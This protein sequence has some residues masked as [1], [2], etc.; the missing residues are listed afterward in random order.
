MSKETEIGT[1]THNSSPETIEL[2][3]RQEPEMDTSVTETSAGELTLKSVDEPIKQATDP[4]LRRVVEL[5]A[6]LAG[7]TEM[8][9]AENSEASGWRRNHD[10]ISPSGNRYDRL[11]VAS[12]IVAS[13]C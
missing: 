1:Q 10:S 4:I 3:S 8:E 5:C 9:S 2:R 12:F 13:S 7:R 11:L 6:L